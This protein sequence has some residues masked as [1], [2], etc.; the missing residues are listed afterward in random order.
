M[1]INQKLQIN[2]GLEYVIRRLKLSNNI[3]L[4]EI[5]K[6]DPGKTLDE[7]DSTTEG[8]CCTYLRVAMHCGEV[9]SYCYDWSGSG[10]TKEIRN[11]FNRQVLK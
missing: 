6:L 4:E 10:P 11:L 1:K 2:E 9:T 7:T 8:Y 3:F 5:V